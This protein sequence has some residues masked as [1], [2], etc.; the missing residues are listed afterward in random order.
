MDEPKFNAGANAL[1]NTLTGMMKK[2]ADKPPVLDFG[3]INTDLSL[4]INSFPRPVPLS[5]YSICR[6]L[7]YDPNIPL[8]ETYV[9]GSHDHPEASPPGTHSHKVKLPKKM[10][11]L[12]AGDK[13][14]VAII[15]NEF[16]VVDIVYNAEHLNSEPDWT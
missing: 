9:D 3:I 12:K 6:Q 15:Q 14:L 7:L 5:D 2:I 4:T 13:V 1:T 11:R 8:T 16:V 10:R